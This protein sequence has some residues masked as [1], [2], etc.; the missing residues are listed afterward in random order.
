MKCISYIDHTMTQVNPPYW[1]FPLTIH[2]S[3]LLHFERSGANAVSVPAVGDRVGRGVM[4]TSAAD[5]S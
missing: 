1:E 5:D 2:S 4:L 3:A